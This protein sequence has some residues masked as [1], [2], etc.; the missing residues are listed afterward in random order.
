MVSEDS[1]QLRP[2]FLAVHRLGDF[3]HLG[4]S[5]HLKMAARRDELDAMREFLEVLALC[6]PQCEVPK[7]RDNH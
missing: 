1:D 3:E 7:E 6:G 4:Q 5:I 2:G